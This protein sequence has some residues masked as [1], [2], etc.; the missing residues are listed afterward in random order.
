VKKV[1]VGFSSGFNE[2]RTMFEDRLRSEDTRHQAPLTCK[3]WH[4]FPWCEAIPT[5]QDSVARGLG[6]FL[7]EQHVRGLGSDISAEIR[8]GMF[9][10]PIS[11]KDYT[12]VFDERRG[13]LF[14]VVRYDTLR[15]VVTYVRMSRHLSLSSTSSQESLA[16]H[17]CAETLDTIKTHIL[18][19]FQNSPT[20]IYDNPSSHGPHTDYFVVYRDEYSTGL[21][22]PTFCTFDVG[23]GTYLICFTYYYEHGCDGV[24]YLGRR[25]VQKS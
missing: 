21:Y 5:P 22:G 9:Q 16:H 23:N 8:S 18:A 17:S 14:D 15:G 4:R 24:V 11:F 13:G 7:S 1:A 19:S 6:A 20:A 25:V 12:V 10:G 3:L 2:Y